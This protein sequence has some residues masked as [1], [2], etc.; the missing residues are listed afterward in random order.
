MLLNKST[1]WSLMAA[2]FYGMMTLSFINTGHAFWLPSILVDL[3]MSAVAGGVF[4]S[5][6]FWGTVLTVLVAGPL[7]DRY[8][9]RVLL[10]GS[11]LCEFI[12]LLIVSYASTEWS[13]Y[14]AV[15]LGSIGTGTIL[16]LATPV[17]FAVYAHARIRVGNL[18]HSFTGIGSVIVILVG[19]LL[20]HSDCTW[21]EMYRLVA[22]LVLPYGLAFLFLPLPKSTCQDDERMKV[23]ELII[24]KSFR[25]LLVSIFLIAFIQVGVGLWLPR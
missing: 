5:C 16:A 23:R 9:F 6:A 15:C 4:L 8:G 7:A 19:L 10:V 13:A 24:K 11:A 22:L 18:L 17:A 1:R 20:F 12:S 2:C 25:F 3:E 21:R 14:A